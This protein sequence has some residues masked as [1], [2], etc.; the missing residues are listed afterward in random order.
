MRSS[1]SSRRRTT[2]EIHLRGHLPPELV[3][4]LGDATHVEAPPQT[5]LLT[6]EIDQRGLDELIARL[7]GL[8]LEL[9]ELRRSVTPDPEEQQGTP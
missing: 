3:E 9:L 1:P 8:G 5:V 7:E 6:D 4:G 2:Y